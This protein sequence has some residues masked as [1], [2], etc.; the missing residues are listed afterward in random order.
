MDAL[1]LIPLARVS[2]TPGIAHRL[3]GAP[4]GNRL[5]ASI[6]SGRWEGERFNGTIVGAGGDWA[7]P[8]P[9]GAI[10]STCARSSRPTTARWST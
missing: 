5:V 7:M 10:C 9:G 3:E 1:E 8:G 6:T 2:V 4:F